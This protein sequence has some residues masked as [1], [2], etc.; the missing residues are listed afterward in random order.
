MNNEQKFTSTNSKL[1]TGGLDTLSTYQKTGILFPQSL[2]IGLTDKCNL[3]CKFCSV[4]ERNKNKSK[5]DELSLDEIKNVIESMPTLKSVELTGAGEPTMHPEIN[6]IIEYLYS[7]GIKIGLITN[8]TKLVNISEESLEML[9]WIRV[10]LSKLDMDKDYSYYIPKIKGTVGLSYVWNKENGLDI[11][12]TIFHT[13]NSNPHV[14]YVRIVPDCLDK[15]T[16]ECIKDVLE[17]KVAKLNKRIHGNI[18]FIQRKPYDVHDSCRIGFIKPFLN[19]DGYFYHCS[20]VP[21]YHRYFHPNWRM[22]HMTEV[23]KIWTRENVKKGMCTKNCKK[24][25]CFFSE[26]NRLIDSIGTK[27]KHGDFV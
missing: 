22:G 17:P 16:Q 3:N 1:L 4:K 11:F 20:A 2:Q 23:S 19:A 10:S 21:L 12:D 7:K 24:G 15:A 5:V 8:G 9:T 6:E 26:Q 14:E 18:F 13:V 25:K 27:L